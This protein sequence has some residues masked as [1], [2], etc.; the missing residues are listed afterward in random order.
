M[1]ILEAVNLIL[2]KLGEHTV[3]AV[4]VKHPTLAI[5][6]PLLEQKRK[7]ILLKG[8]WFNEYDTVLYPDAEGKIA[9]PVTVLAFRSEYVDVV[10]RGPALYN[11]VERSYTFTDPVSG[12]LTEDVSFELLPESIANFIL[13]SA[14]V[15]AYAT[16]IGLEKVVQVWDQESRSA[17]AAATAEH[18]RNKNYSTRRSP[19]WWRFVHALR[20]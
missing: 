7:E 4:D 16:D 2:P 5:I 3:T 18:L 15:Q 12:T 1:Q 19:R 13:Y 8:W 9:A 11:L 20:G 14:C 10:F 17:N 6:L